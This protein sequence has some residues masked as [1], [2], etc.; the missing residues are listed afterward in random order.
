ME[1]KELD[2]LSITVTVDNFYD[3]LID[4]PPCGRRFRTEPGKSIYAEHGLSFFVTAFVHDKKYSFFFDFGVDGE[5]LLHN[6]K[7]LGI[8]AKSASSLVLSHGHFDHYG[9]LI[10]LVKYFDSL[11]V[12]GLP[13]YVGYGCFARRFS[14]R[15]GQAEL[16][17]LGELSRNDIEGVTRVYELDKPIEF[18]PGCYLTGK[19]EM[20]KDYEEIPDN[21]F[22]LREKNLIKDDFS[23]ELAIF[24]KVK[25]KGL[26]ILSGCAHRGIVNTVNQVVRMTKIE[27]V[28]AI[29]GGF[30]LIHAD[31]KRILTTIADLE[32]FSP[33]YVVPC[34]CSGFFS[35]LLFTTTMGERSIINTVGTTYTFGR[36]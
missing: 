13:L 25:G 23:E 32:P 16:T 2:G 14:K 7:V 18:L 12:K 29:I 8:E 31:E 17:D 34:H 4:D 30:H 1:I 10:G 9:G 6:L 15:K 3:A 24:F 35:R 26:V 36:S 27:K 21:L 33:D 20:E 19:I 28:H 22:A 5:L 11:G